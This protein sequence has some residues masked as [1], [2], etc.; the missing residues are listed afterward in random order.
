M[1][2]VSACLNLYCATIIQCYVTIGVLIQYVVND[3]VKRFYFTL[4]HE[5]N[6]KDN[7]VV[8]ILLNQYITRN[9]IYGLIMH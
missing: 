4:V 2:V 8:N 9:A 6:D 5:Y 1:F 3:T 7:W